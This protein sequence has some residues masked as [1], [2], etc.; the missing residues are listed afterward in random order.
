M[1]GSVCAIYIYDMYI[2]IIIIIIITIN[3]I[4]IIIGLILFVLFI[5]FLVYLFIYLFVYDCLCVCFLSVIF[6]QVNLLILQVASKP[7]SPNSSMLPI[8]TW[9]TTEPWKASHGSQW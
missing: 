2:T 9:T 1:S 7:G 6:I 8:V 4:V 5:Y 3:V